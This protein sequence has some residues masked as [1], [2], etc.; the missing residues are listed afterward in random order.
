M[1]NRLTLILAFAFSFSLSL[2][3]LSIFSF[4]GNLSPLP[5]SLSFRSLILLV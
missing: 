4:R 5:F 3:L 2:P 1:A